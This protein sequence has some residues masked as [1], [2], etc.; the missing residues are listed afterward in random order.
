[1][2][3]IVF[4]FLEITQFLE[5]CDLC[6]WCVYFMLAVDFQRWGKNLMQFADQTYNSSAAIRN[7]RVHP[8][9]QFLI[10]L[11]STTYSIKLFGSW[12]NSFLLA[13][14]L[15]KNVLLLE[16]PQKSPQMNG[17]KVSHLIAFQQSNRAIA[18][19]WDEITPI[20]QTKVCAWTVDIP[21]PLE[22]KP[23][24]D[25]RRLLGR[26]NHIPKVQVAALSL[27]VAARRFSI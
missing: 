9:H 27:K 25:L 20:Y 11:R 10:K 5:M 22:R 8:L 2:W 15:A 16:G 13:Q 4:K 19:A 24:S 6:F 17:K 14:L 3:T 12:W 18:Q 1:M 26:T 7:R 21:V 23:P